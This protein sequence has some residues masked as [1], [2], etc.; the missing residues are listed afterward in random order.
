MQAMKLWLGLRR[1]G[2][3]IFGREAARRGNEG[4]RSG[5]G[6]LGEQRRRG[7]RSSIS[8]IA[9]VYLSF[10][11]REEHGC[12]APLWA[13]CRPVGAPNPSVLSFVEELP[14]SNQQPDPL[15]AAVKYLYGP[16]RDWRAFR[17]LLLEHKDENNIE[18]PP[19]F[20]IST[21]R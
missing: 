21:R 15:F 17:H 2:S 5:T 12:S 20:Y 9:S 11:E 4:S 19:S 6:N 13:L 10:A 8:Q 7:S 18:L 14:Q 1:F 3:R 16:P